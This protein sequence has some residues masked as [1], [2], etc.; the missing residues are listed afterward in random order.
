MIRPITKDN[1]KTCVPCQ[2][3]RISWQGF[4]LLDTAMKTCTKCKVEKE[5]SEFSKSK[6]SKDGFQSHCK[7]C[8]KEYHQNSREKIAEYQKQY[9][10][11][12]R[13][14]LYR[15]ARQYRRDNCEKIT[16]REKRYRRDNYEKIAEYQRQYERTRRASDPAFRLSKNLRARVRHALNGKSKSA[17]TMEL[18]GCD[19]EFLKQHLQ[20]QFT[21]GMTWENQGQW[22][23]DHIKPCA[24]FDLS[25][26]EQQRECFHYSNL[27]PLWAED[28]M[29]KGASYPKYARYIAK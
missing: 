24:S 14:K 3:G 29:R 8:V 4:L 10:R 16:E 9:Q 19:V 12:N 11:G 2:E 26:P 5:L 15:K 25:K 22:H 28:N 20:S 21:D 17:A 18:L 6:R 27:R 13:A 7:D 1:L 23:V